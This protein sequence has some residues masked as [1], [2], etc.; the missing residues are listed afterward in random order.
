MRVA[1][2][3]FDGTLAE[4]PGLWSQCLA[5]L[6]NA[7]TGEARHGR[8][9][10]VRHLQVGF[11]WHSPQQPHLDIR[12]ASEWWALLHPT[13]ASA[14]MAGGGFKSTEAE[15]LAYEVRAEYTNPLRW[16]VFPDVET[17]LT[18]LTKQGWQHVMLSNHVPELPQL[19]EALGLAK[20]FAAIHTSA[21]SGYEKPHPKAF[22]NALPVGTEAR[23]AV[24]VGDNEVAD[25][26]GAAAVGIR[27]FL[28]RKPSPVLGDQVTT[29]AH[30]TAALSEA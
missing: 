20:H 16:R 22:L 25:V 28:V 26:E 17:T 30:V 5:D 4:R 19:V 1:L 11:P 7:R 23:D 2:W 18:G 24:M 14:F 29:L 27:G 21:M 10:F 13:I 3:D 9:D 12:T 6:A 15:I 8:E